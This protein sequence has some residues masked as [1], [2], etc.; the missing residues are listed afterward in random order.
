MALFYFYAWLLL[1]QKQ[2]YRFC[3]PCSVLNKLC[4]Y[5]FRQLSQALFYPVKLLAF[6]FFYQ[7]LRFHGF[8]M[9]PL[10]CFFCRNISV[11]KIRGCGKIL[12]RHGRIQ[13]CIQPWSHF[14]SIHNNLVCIK[15]LLIRSSVCC[16]LCGIKPTNLLALFFS[17][18]RSKEPL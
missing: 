8:V 13:Y 17:H 6:L 14:L 16:V 7:R 2:A 5:T 9:N 4:K 15:K 12:I 10:H 1:F 18:F 11:D 3:R